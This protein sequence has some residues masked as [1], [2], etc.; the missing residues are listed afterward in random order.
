MSQIIHVHQIEK[1]VSILTAALIILFF[2][3]CRTEE[4]QESEPRTPSNELVD[5]HLEY[6]QYSPDPSDLVIS[7]SDYRDKL[8]GFWLGS[9]SPTGQDW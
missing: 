8:Y 7:R 9:V 6:K 4:K 2:S 5:P 1:W 3:S